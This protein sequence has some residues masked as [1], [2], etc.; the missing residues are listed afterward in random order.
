MKCNNL[1]RAEFSSLEPSNEQ[2]RVRRSGCGARY[3]C[4]ERALDTL[5]GQ[6]G[7]LALSLGGLRLLLVGGDAARAGHRRQLDCSQ[8]RHGQRRRLAASALDSRDCSVSRRAL[9]WRRTWRTTRSAA[10]STATPTTAMTA[11]PAALVWNDGLPAA[12]GRARQPSCEQAA[13]ACLQL[14]WRKLESV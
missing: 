7:V 5:C 11:R 8:A 13:G 12:G 14:G 4:H 6:G 1:V 10:A 9:R 2:K 3:G